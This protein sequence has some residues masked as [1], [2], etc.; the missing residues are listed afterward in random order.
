MDHGEVLGSI[1]E[2]GEVRGFSLSAGAMRARV[3]N[4]GATL[5]ALWAPDR[6]GRSENVVLG[7]DTLEPYLAGTPYFG[8][9]VGRYANRIGG[10][11]FTLDGVSHQ[12]TANEGASQLHGGARGFDKR[13][14]HVVDSGA[15]SVALRYLSADGE[16]GFPGEL[17]VDISYRIEPDRLILEYRATT[18]KPTPVNLTH[19]SYFNLSGEALREITDHDLMID[20]AAMTPVDATQIPTGEIRPVAG[21][22]F[23]FQRARRIGAAID[24]DDE[25]IRIGGGYDHNFVLNKPQPAACA[26]AA[27]LSNP[28]SGRRMQVWTSEPGLQIYSGNHL[29][30]SLRGRS[31][32]F[33]RRT[34]LCLEP[35]HFPDSP[36]KPAFPST[37]LRPGAV[38]RSRTELRFSTFG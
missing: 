20:A 11:R 8:A 18:S 23:D 7:F 25:Q 17:R 22:P 27:I 19:H 37:I 28:V 6:T 26:C 21:T 33:T 38:Y 29:D 3:M 36:N 32:A 30:G 12:L 16:E 1:P 10:A 15:A 31:G 4:Y 14:W 13:L 9:T 24:A 35:Q 34:G 2:G 5:M